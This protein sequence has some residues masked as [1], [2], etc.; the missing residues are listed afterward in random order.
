M[1]INT[2]TNRQRYGATASA[3]RFQR[4]MADGPTPQADAAIAVLDALANKPKR[5]YNFTDKG[6]QTESL[7]QKEIM[8]ALRRHPK[9]AWYARFNSSN[10]SITDETGQARYMRANTQKGMS[11]LMGMLHGGRLFAIEVKSP[12]GTLYDHQAAFLE[13]IRNGG[14]IAG[15]A[16][17]VSDAIALIEVE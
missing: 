16:R 12:T 3:L 8:Q 10:I 4:A 14:G 11:D 9:V 6:G 15:V 5:E 1:K 7:I 17:S 13:T 2:K